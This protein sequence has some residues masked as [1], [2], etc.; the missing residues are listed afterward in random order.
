MKQ[1][2]LVVATGR[3][4]GEMGEEGPKLKRKKDV[5]DV[6]QT[7]WTIF[8]INVIY[9]CIYT[10]IYANVYDIGILYIIYIKK[11]MN[12]CYFQNNENKMTY[13]KSLR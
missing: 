4:M 12:T 7:F 13:S 8:Q 5:V 1:A 10:H 11:L 3:G 2:R 9:I 6:K